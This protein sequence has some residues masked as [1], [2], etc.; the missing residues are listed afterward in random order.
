MKDEEID[1]RFKWKVIYPDGSSA[2]MEELP[3]HILGKKQQEELDVIKFPDG[4]EFRKIQ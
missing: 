3:F 4:S 2:L 1:S